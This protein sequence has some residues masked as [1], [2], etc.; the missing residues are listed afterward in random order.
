MSNFTPHTTTQLPKSQQY[1]QLNALTQMENAIT[2]LALAFPRLSQ[3]HEALTIK[4][5]TSAGDIYMMKQ[6]L[7]NLMMKENNLPLVSEAPV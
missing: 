5:S 6:R 1:R 3:N 4:L 7:I 2:E